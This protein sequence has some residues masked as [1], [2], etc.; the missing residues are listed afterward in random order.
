MKVRVVAYATN[1]A[2]WA[3]AQKLRMSC[4]EQRLD[5]RIYREKHPEWTW[6]QAVRWKPQFCL[7]ELIEAGRLGFDGILYVDAD[8]VFRNQP[9]WSELKGSDFGVHFFRRSKHHAMELLTGT[10]WIRDCQS[11]RDFLLDWVKATER[12]GDCSTPE[13]ASLAAVLRNPYSLQILDLPPSWVYIFD[14]FQK[15]YP[16]T[17][18]VIE[19]F[20]ASRRL[21]R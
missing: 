12:V 20:Q 3:E 21:R 8:A 1:D 7:R 17:R 10:I 9:D 2:Y 15:I 4:G 16:H 19:H 14:D 5:Y 18:P 13:Q 6:S 11:T